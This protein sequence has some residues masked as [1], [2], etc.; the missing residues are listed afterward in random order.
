MSGQADRHWQEGE[1]AAASGNLAMARRAYAAALAE[2]PRHVPSLLGMSQVAGRLGSHREALAATMAAFHASPQAAPLL[3]GLARRLR[4]FNE[5]EALCEC[6]AHPRFAADAPAQAMAEAAVMLSS[7]G[8]N[9]QARALVE[10]AIQKAP[11]HAASHYVRGNLRAFAGEFELADEDYARGLTL[12]PRLFQC[13][14]M[15]AGLRTQTATS[16]HVDLLR[17][18]LRSATPGGMGE[19]YL[20]YALHKELHD[21]GDYA[22]AWIALEKGNA[23]KRS[24]VKFDAGESER[25]L[26]GLAELCDRTFCTSGGQASL[27]ATPIFIVGMYRSGTTLL[28]RILAGHDEVADAGETYAFAEQMRRATDHATSGPLDGELLRR[29][30]ECDYAAVGRGYADASRWLSRGKGWFTE[31]L[32][33]NFQ[34]MGFIAKAVPSARF[35]HMQRDPMDTCFSNLRTLFS[36]A[37]AYSYRQDELVGYYKGYRR[38]MDHWRDVL[39]GRMLDVDYR[40]LVLEP[41]VQARRIADFCGLDYRPAMVEVQREGGDVA[42]ASVAQVRGG[43]STQRREAWRPYEA[44]LGPMIEGLRDP[45]CQTSN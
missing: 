39:P 41:E 1:R 42:T 22:E 30:R 6:L 36:D 44:W 38:L 14:W 8:A 37:A 3:F 34:L 7:I 40:Q 13:S 15:R 27:G 16:N 19:V 45:C 17:R 10:K 9:S 43:I 23:I 2:A 25:L 35:L 31:K 12:D 24:L 33:A 21:L 29:A 26:A 18:Q 11:G 32:P 4:H 20:Q 28:E 5:Y